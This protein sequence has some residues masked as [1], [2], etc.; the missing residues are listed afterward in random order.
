MD[1]GQ[2]V[3]AHLA[4]LHNGPGKHAVPELAHSVYLHV[5]VYY[6]QLG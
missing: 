5:H 1:A 2:W 3:S 4:I 6:G